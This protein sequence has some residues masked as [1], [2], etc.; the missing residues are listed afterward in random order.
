MTKD[1]QAKLI[2]SSFELK[3]NQY[4]C[5]STFII[6]FAEKDLEFDREDFGDLVLD[7]EEWGIIDPPG[8]NK[9]FGSKIN[10]ELL[11]DLWDEECR[12]KL[13]IKKLKEIG[14]LQELA[15]EIFP[16]IDGF[17]RVNGRENIFEELPHTIDTLMNFFQ[18][19]NDNNSIEIVEYE[20]G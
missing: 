5:D 3:Q 13:T 6:F 20:N 18:S 1:W 2:S 11:E 17:F 12:T 14:D 19:E 8:P 16:Y 4:D 15:R 9:G 7:Y 10:P